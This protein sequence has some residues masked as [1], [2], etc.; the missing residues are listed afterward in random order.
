MRNTTMHSKMIERRE[1]FK[2]RNY[3]LI[4]ELRISPKKKNS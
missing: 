4:A 1:E 2:Y 3:S